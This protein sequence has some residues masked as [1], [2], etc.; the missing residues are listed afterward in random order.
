M[1][2]EILKYIDFLKVKGVKNPFSEVQ[3]FLK[4]VFN[5]P[6][7]TIISGDFNFTP[8]MENKLKDFCLK[9]AEGV[10][11][12][13]IVG[14]TYFWGR[15]FLVNKNVL[16]PRPE[17]ELIVDFVL[18]KLGKKFKGMILDC[19]TG[20]GNLA[21]TFAAELPNCEVF[22]CDYSF[23]ALKVAKKNSEINEANVVFFRCDKLLCV[24]DN[25]FDVIVA[26]PPY[27]G[28]NERDT[29]ENEVLNEP[30]IALFGGEKGYEFYVDFFEQAKSVIKKK[31]IIVFEIGYNQRE[32]IE[33]LI[34][35]IMGCV[36][37]YFLKDLNGYFRVGVVEN[38]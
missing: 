9:R 17:T 7:P 32:I 1:K 24:K 33:S 26:N 25:L 35:N 27:I 28:L 5:I 14:F 2:K 20:S 12:A 3:Q 22:G 19:C 31:G 34:K 37:F 11:F 38:A 23:D 10:P 36:N 8:E 30:P 18:K 29:L 15:K 21:V 16:I 6:L 4:D 13:Y